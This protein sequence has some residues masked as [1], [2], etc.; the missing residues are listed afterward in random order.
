[1]ERREMKKNGRTEEK[2]DE[3]K[4]KEGDLGRYLPDC[5]FAF[6]RFR[7][8]IFTLTPCGLEEV[9]LC[10]QRGFHSHRR[11]SV[12]FCVRICVE[13]IVAMFPVWTQS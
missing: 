13:E 8:G 2:K 3:N 12:L 6:S 9:S 1:M 11:D 5:D 4:R 7:I 10:P